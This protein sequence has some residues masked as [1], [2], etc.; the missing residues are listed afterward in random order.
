MQ[1]WRT[2]LGQDKCNIEARQM[3]R[4]RHDTGNFRD[5]T[6]NEVKQNNKHNTKKLKDEQHETHQKT[7][8]GD[9]RRYS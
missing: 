7:E 3:Q 1:R 9:E 2:T 4:C 8:E 5:T 6:P